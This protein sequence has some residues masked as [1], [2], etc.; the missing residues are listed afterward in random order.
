MDS[1]IRNISCM[2]ARILAGAI[3]VAILMVQSAHMAH[4]ASLAVNTSAVVSEVAAQ[5]AHAGHDTMHRH[6]HMQINGDKPSGVP[7][8]MA[9]DC[10]TLS[11]CFVIDDRT[12]SVPVVFVFGL[13]KYLNFNSPP[14]KAHPAMVH[15]RPPRTV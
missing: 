7:Q 13:S 15:E 12:R 6:A 10:V 9:G 5:T 1:F 2:T 14:S 8:P 4:A 3:V 11:C